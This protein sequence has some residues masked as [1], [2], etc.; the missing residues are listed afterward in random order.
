M[1]SI[2][3]LLKLRKDKCRDKT[4]GGVFA[5]FCQVKELNRG[6][7]HIICHF[8]NINSPPHSLYA[9]ESLFFWRNKKSPVSLY[10]YRLYA[11]RGFFITSIMKSDITLHICVCVCL[12]YF[13]TYPNLLLFFN[14]FLVLD[15]HKGL[16]VSSLGNHKGTPLHRTSFSKSYNS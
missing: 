7:Q 6:Q 11:K 9:K 16:P 14:V 3:C 13:L 10:R 8:C 15:S 1:D 4:K 2:L 12:H 5:Y